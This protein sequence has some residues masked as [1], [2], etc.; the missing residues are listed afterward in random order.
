MAFIL[1][2]RVKEST[3][4]TGTGNLSLAGAAATFDTF[5]SY[6]SNG[7]TTFYAVVHTSSGI[8]EWEVGLA[9]WNTGNTL[10]RTTVLSGSNGT[11][12]VNFSA[13]AKDI[14]MTL[15]ADKLL[16]LDANGD[17]DIN[18]GTI[19]GTVI[20]AAQA[21]AS[22][23]TTIDATGNVSVGGQL[24][25][26]DWIDLSAQ[27]SHPAHGEGR[28]WYDSIHKTINYYSDDAGVVHELGI[29]EHARVYNETGSTLSKGTPVHFA[30]TKTS[31][32]THVPT[33]AAA[34]A[35]SSTKYKSEGMVAADIANNSY[36]YIITAGRLEGI[37][38]SHLSIGQ[39]FTG[40]TD[41]ST[42]TAA[43]VYPNFPMCLGFVVRSDA[44]NGVV[45]LAQ[46][47][48]SIKSF[49]VQMD[50]HIGGSLTIDGDLNVTG[51]TNTTSTSDVTAGAPFYRANE[52]D[53]IG[54]A[55]TT[56]TG[57]GLDDAFF[58]GHFTGTASTNYY[59][60]IDG[61]GTPDTF[62]VS[63]DNFSTTI[64]TG[65][66]ITGSEQ[67]IHSADNIS[68][69]F[70][71]TTGHTLNDVWTGTASPINVDTGFFSNRNTGTS[72]VGYTHMGLFYD[73]SESKWRLVDEY[74]PVPAGTIDTGHSSYVTGTIAANLEGN[75]TGNITGNVAGNAATA[76][77][78]ESARTIGGVSFDGTANID[79]A[80]VNTAGN[81]DTT[82][83]AATA[84]ALE[85]AR[86]IQ[87]SGDVTGSA[88]FDGT[89]NINI[90][91]TVQDDS[92]A[93]VISNVD[94]LQTALN[95]KVPKSRTITAGNG[96]TG[97]G[98]LTAN[99]TLT[100]GGGSGITVN[101]NDIAID[102]SYTGFDGRY[103]TE[104]EA[105]S[106]FVNVT[107]DTIQTLQIGSNSVGTTSDIALTANVAINAENS[108]SFGMTNASSGY[109]RWL[110]G[111]TSNT[112]GTAGG[113][114]K[115]R[116]NK[117]GN[118]TLS[119][120]VDG[121][122][123][124]ARNAVLT[125]TT[126]TA[127][128]ALPKAGG[129]MTGELQVNARLDV[130]T[131]TQNDAEIRVYKAD[132]NISDHIQFYNGTTRMG[133]IGCQDTTWLRINQATAKNIYTP[134]YIRADGGFY[135]DDTN[136]GINGSGNF[137][138]GTIT[139]A[140]DA[141]VGNWNTAYT[142]ANAALQRTGGTMT[143]N[144]TINDN[145]E[146]RLGTGSDF[147]MDFNG[148][149]TY[150]RS[151]AHAGG[152]IYFQGEDTEGTNQA[153]LYIYTDTSE[154]YLKLFQNGGER[155][156]TLSGGVGVTGLTV[157]AVDANPRNANGLQVFGSGDEKIVLSGSTNPYIRWQEGSVDKAYIQWNGG[158]F[159]DFRNQETGMFKFQ[160]T[161]QGQ[162]SSLVL[163]RND[164]I[165]TTA[166]DFGSIGF[167]HTDGT[168]DF[169]TQTLAQLPARIVAEAAENM[170]SGDD[171]ARLMFFVKAVNADKA[172]NSVEAMRIEH[173]KTVQFQN[174]IYVP[175]Q[176]IHTADT[177]TYMQ[178]HTTNQ[179]RVVVGGT[180]R[181][182]VKDS[183]PHVF[184]NGTL[185]S[186]SD[187]RLKK[188]IK[189][190]DNSLANI[191]QLEG[192]TF[193]WRDDGSHGEG[194]IAQQVEPIIPG[195]VNTDEET[196]MKSINYVGL[197]SHLVEAIKEQQIQIDALKAIHATSNVTPE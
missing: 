81:Q 126:N 88:S 13:G 32:G 180:E 51:S 189:P 1:K 48:H 99:R 95:D 128:A 177:D 60:K 9:T 5:Q 162:A 161:V 62:A 52:G 27:A 53:A 102:S 190:L 100:V 19:D 90:T 50:Q 168:P 33:V 72:G 118:L 119:G 147:R 142:T 114:E 17:V 8:D 163:I 18:G 185:S 145:I 138:G 35:T 64:S 176:I 122:D 172:T 112:G 93:H 160:S 134:R 10:S 133:E 111:N 144:V 139:G 191:C 80:G 26:A 15:P 171:G 98:N 153:L 86:T 146:L 136:K 154:T 181:L 58:A 59:V 167:G 116:L 2:D 196:G 87:V 155:L 37:D 148:T 120:T 14:F 129:T 11:S 83:N 166:N 157:G 70:G 77:A 193:D 151:F 46:Q 4:T 169:P 197:I 97:G 130:G 66:A 20:G 56:F 127:N 47:N 39:F 109:Y 85:N 34:N 188:N 149:H 74:D 30:G 43:P 12:A 137:I 170:G 16:H 28:L 131:G 178:F 89:S 186:G 49:R 150:F 21:A 184:I 45:F 182:E 117:D 31:N 44:T 82:G 110:F 113:T 57:S 107:G 141:N 192:V 103:Y 54:D 65:N 173:N 73:A 164:T 108:L 7:D 61:V 165:T 132:N 6:L 76:S 29:E 67:M 143:G 84:T 41:G 3:V 104:T 91:T 105:D 78:L 158:G 106:R 94:G 123:I 79:L 55:N 175:D 96:L 24:D 68:V 40:I 152:N 92:H 174:D 156:R 183:S 22:N 179:W 115:M 159:L 135:V 195:V 63:T 75:V 71:A 25:V 121:V 38:T 187:E 124:A 140:S 36:G 101:A 23:F 125:T 69:K 194:F 42:Q